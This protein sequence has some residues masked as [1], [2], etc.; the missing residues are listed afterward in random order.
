MRRATGGMDPVRRALQQQMRQ[1]TDAQTAFHHGQNGVVILYSIAHPDPGLP[2]LRFHR[3]IVL[4]LQQDEAF[5]PQLLQA[6][7]LRSGQGMFPGQD[8]R[9]AV[10]QQGQKR[11]ILGPR[12]DHQPQ[13]H[14]A[15]PEPLID[16]G[17]VT[18]LQLKPNLGIQLPEGLQPL[19]QPVAGHAGKGADGHRAAPQVPNLVQLV[20]KHQ[21]LAH[22]L[23]QSRQQTPAL[24]RGH[25][26]PLAPNKQGQSELRLGGF[27]NLTDPG[28]GIVQLLR[29]AGQA[30][31]LGNFGQDAICVVSHK[32]FSC[33]P[34]NI[35]ILQDALYAV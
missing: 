14:G 19:G 31:G 22:Q 33:S 2:Q 1:H 29:R 3:G 6:Q 26:A 9:I 8:H 25:H 35:F 24:R 23:L 10:L 18:Q 32:L 13:V 28:L 34:R 15:L 12:V 11:Q 17:H 21:L 5:P 30:A 27:Q 4:R 16:M 7:L 20:Q